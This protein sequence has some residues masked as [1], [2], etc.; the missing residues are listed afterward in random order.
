MGDDY[1]STE[2]VDS[3]RQ[4]FA[5]GLSHR[6]IA[7]LWN[8]TKGT[9]SGKAGRMGLSKTPDGRQASQ[10]GGNGHLRTQAPRPRKPPP[11][12]ILAP[13]DTTVRYL[14]LPELTASTCHWPID[15]HPMHECD[16]FAAFC[17][18][19]VRSGRNYCDE[20][21]AAAIRPIQPRPLTARDAAFFT[22]ERRR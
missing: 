18:A 19:D 13:M 7:L 15:M 4:L 5:E 8:V 17:G 11:A 16:A 2:R 14:A 9:I 3:L 21:H 1:W 12:P 6:Q 10:I 22:R 20:H